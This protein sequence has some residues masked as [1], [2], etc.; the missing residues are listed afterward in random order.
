[1]KFG[2]FCSVKCGLIWANNEIE[3]KRNFKN[4]AG[5]SL[6]NDN[7]SKLEILANRMKSFSKNDLRN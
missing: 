6:S 2:N 3:R 7:M 1:M 4:G 5:S